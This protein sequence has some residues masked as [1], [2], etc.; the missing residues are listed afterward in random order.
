MVSHASST[1]GLPSPRGWCQLLWQGRLGTLDH[2]W[3]G[4]SHFCYVWIL[5]I[6]LWIFG[7]FSITLLWR[8]I[9]IMCAG[10][11]WEIDWLTISVVYSNNISNFLWLQI[12]KRISSTITNPQP[13]RHALIQRQIINLVIFWK[14]C[15]DFSWFTSYQ[16]SHRC[17]YGSVSHLY[18]KIDESFWF[19]NSINFTVFQLS[20]VG[21]RSVIQVN[22]FFWENGGWSWG[23]GV[24]VWMCV[25]GG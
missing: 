23:W 12:K 16:K 25:C 19:Y 10:T 11:L 17:S 7:R 21:K 18:S 13:R 9:L 6:R 8:G 4:W 3:P 15:R 24:G 1:C 14:N 2:L 22:L 5:P 20:P